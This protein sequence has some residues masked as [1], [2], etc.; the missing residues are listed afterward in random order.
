MSTQSFE[1][2]RW[3]LEDLLPATKGPELDQIL[4][5]LVSNVAEL[6]ACRDQLSPDLPEAEFQ[7]LMAVVEKISALAN[8][9]GAYG[10]LWYSEDTQDQD[11]LAFRGRMEKLLT[12]VQ[13]RTLF[14]D[15][16]W[17]GLEDGPAER[18]LAVSGDNAYYLKSLRR[19]KPHTLSEPEEK[20]INLK[21]VNGVQALQTVYDMITTQ[22]TFQLE[23]DGQVQKLTRSELTPYIMGPSPELRAAAYQ[24]MYRVFGKQ[25]AVLS[26][27][28]QHVARDW[29]SENLSLRNFKSPISVRNLGNDIPDPVVDTLLEVCRHNAGLFQRYFRLK[30]EWLGMDK[31]RRYDIYA[32]LSASDKRYPF[33]EAADMV[34]DSLGAFSP[35]L[36]SHARRVFAE[37]HLD[38]EVRPRKDTGA[39]CYGALPGITPWV[40]VNYNGRANDVATLAHEL[41]HAV[42]ALMAADHTPLTFHSSLPLAETASVFSEMLLVERMLRDEPDPLVRR[43]ILV[44]SVDD[45]YATVMRQ[46]Y[47]VLFERDAH[48]LIEE[49]STTDELAGRYFANLQEQ[50][51]EAIDLSDEFRWE[52][53]SIPHIYATPFYCYAYSFGQL[54]VLALYRQYRTEGKSFIPKYLKI[55]AHGG[56]RSPAEILGEAGIDMTNRGFWQGG[57]EVI[58][59]MIGEL[60]ELGK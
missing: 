56:S 50:F 38:A 40:L 36:S 54:L 12:D 18:L 9:L 42:H 32:P 44:R 39:F 16:W 15:L 33:G 58:A 45:A 17:K 21:D 48:A 31:L 4:A 23:V 22:F 46:A 14:F 8:R 43:N 29:A 30:A 13:N 59:E 57:F 10:Y 28:Y 6:E 53:I 51:G 11:A 55:L 60:E 37:T 27:I 2:T 3:S 19:F 7:R 34:L 25:S 20:V 26:Q 24:E 41:G 52:W 1:L 35:I 47:F 49:A 5:D